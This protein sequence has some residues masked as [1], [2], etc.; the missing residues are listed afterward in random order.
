M[1]VLGMNGGQARPLI[2]SR[3]RG[4]RRG[5]GAG[6]NAA[7]GALGFLLGQAEAAFEGGAEVPAEAGFGQ[8]GADQLFVEHFVAVPDE[9][10]V[11]AVIVEAFVAEGKLHARNRP[12][13]EILRER[14][15]FGAP[16]FDRIIFANRFG[17]IDAFQSD[18]CA[19][20][21]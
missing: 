15:S 21:H 12:L 7:S 19:G 16:G 14:A 10:Q 8:A 1:A 2:L 4:R 5:A 17:S 9:G 6:P 20:L 3:P 13:D 18:P 11:A